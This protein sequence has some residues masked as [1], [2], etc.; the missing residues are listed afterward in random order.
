MSEPFTERRKHRRYFVKDNILLYNEITFA[1]I[2]DISEGG[3]CCRF[4]TEAKDQHL[5]CSI[6]DLLNAA[7]KFH[8]RGLPCLDLNCHELASTT[9]SPPLTVVRECRLEFRNLTESQKQQLRTF[10]EFAADQT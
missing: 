2:I 6:V 5:P 9:G 8:V 4:I 1:E 10:I 7:D 3:V